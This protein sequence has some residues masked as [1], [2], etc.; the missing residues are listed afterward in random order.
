MLNS[1]SENVL[2]GEFTQMVWAATRFFGCSK[3]KSATGKVGPEAVLYTGK[4]AMES[5]RGTE[6][7]LKMVR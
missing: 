1:H 5:S 6:I 4:K 3:A 7:G 2:S